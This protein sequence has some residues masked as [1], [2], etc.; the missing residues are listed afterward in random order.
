M[1]VRTFVLMELLEDRRLM[2]LPGDYYDVATGQFVS[3]GTDKHYASD[4]PAHAVPVVNTEGA[5]PPLLIALDGTS[6]TADAPA[7][8][9]ISSAAAGDWGPKFDFANDVV[10]IH[11]AVMPNGKVL[12]WDF[13]DSWVW[14][15][16]QGNA[17]SLL[18]TGRPS[19]YT[20]DKFHLM[21]C[22]GHSWLADGKLYVTGGQVDGGGS[23]K[24]ALYDPTSDTW[25]PGPDLSGG[26]WYPT[27]TTLPN[28][29]VLVVSGSPDATYGNADPLP[30]IYNPKTNTLRDLTG[31]IRRQPL[32]PFMYVAPNG[33]VFDAGP[34]Q[35]TWF[36][37]TSGTGS[38]TQGPSSNY[39][40]RDYGSSV[41]Y[42]P[43]KVMIVGGSRDIWGEAPTDT[44]ETIDLNTASPTWKYADPMSVG[45]RQFTATI[46]PDGNVVVIGGSSAKGF[47]TAAVETTSGNIDASVYHAEVWNPDA[48]AGQQWTTLASMS[49][50]RLY[51]HTVLLLPDGRLLSMGGGHPQGELL[52]LDGTGD[53]NAGVD[54]NH[55][56]AE[57]F[58]PPY[59]FNG[60]RPTISAAPNGIAYGGQ[61]AVDTPEAADIK[62]VTLVKLGSVTHGVNM[63]QRFD[64]LTFTR[65]GTRLTVNS[66]AN[67]NRMPPGHYM[68]FVLNSKGVPSVAKIISVGASARPNVTTLSDSPD[69]VTAGASVTLTATGVTDDHGVGSV[70]FFRESNGVAGL[71]FTAGGDALI[72]TDTSGADGWKITV[73]TSGMNGGA[74]RYYARAV[75]IYGLG[76]GAATTTNTV[77]AGTSGGSASISGNVFNDYDVDGARDSNEPALSGWTVFIDADKD[78]A[79]DAG[80]KTAQTNA[81]GNYA[82]TGLAAG[83]YRVSSVAQSGY[84]RTA[85]GSGFHDVTLT[86]GQAVASRNFA[87]TRKVTIS[88]TVFND[89]NGDGV[90]QSGEPV[91]NGWKVFVDD[92]KDGVHDAAEYSA[93]TD[94]QGNYAFK[95]LWGDRV[96]RVRVAPQTGWRVSSPESGYH[97]VSAAWAGVYTGRN[98]GVSQKTLIAGTVFADANSSQSRDSG[99]SGLS[100]WRIYIDHNNNGLF[101]TGDA[102]ILTDSAGNFRFRAQSAGSFVVRVVQQSG[103]TRTTPTGGAF[104][105]SLSN[106]GIKTGLLFG[107][108]RI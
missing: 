13:V 78:G 10:P 62:K 15:P 21:F 24:S 105:F 2:C 98:F 100:G 19:N 84:R 49:T 65:S 68:L 57:I 64:A 43:G 35:E 18:N 107:Q 59:L 33:R 77:Q 26:R 6:L 16:A 11:A 38:W 86:A 52:K 79:L 51:H 91:A 103:Y 22:A 96:H 76:G 31:A 42:R 99:E 17:G 45:R 72:G 27:N 67:A 29:E 37:N 63:D 30:Q 12:L 97:D 93:L 39:G 82:F 56:D 3:A 102:G 87:Q 9:I 60:S 80:E 58:S 61:F 69:P 85:P 50:R 101:D 48:P 44:L 81:S 41:M 8:A 28:G 25:I 36:L 40:Y 53:R 106:G 47:N 73:S 95:L 34:T 20:D 70:K 83:S 88:G 92:D 4:V 89:S 5:A 54:A 66:P 7:S 75:D 1:A 94:S 104:S 55:P 74:Y 46:T 71:Q 23:E 90:R 108:K 14:N 32:Y